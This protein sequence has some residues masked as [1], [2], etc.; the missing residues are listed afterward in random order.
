MPQIIEPKEQFRSF[1]ED[2][3]MAALADTARTNERPIFVA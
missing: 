3:V 2:E 1:S